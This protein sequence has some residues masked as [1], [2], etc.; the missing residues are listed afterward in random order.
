MVLIQRHVRKTNFSIWRHSVEQVYLGYNH[1]KSQHRVYITRLSSRRDEGEKGNLLFTFQPILSLHVF[2]LQEECE[3]ACVKHHQDDLD[4]E[5]TENVAANATLE[6]GDEGAVVTKDDDG[7]DIGYWDYYNALEATT[8]DK[9]EGKAGGKENKKNGENGEIGEDPDEAGIIEVEDSIKEESSSKTNNGED[10]SFRSGNII[11]ENNTSSKSTSNNSTS[12]NS[13]SSNST[14]TVNNIKNG[15]TLGKNNKNKS[16]NSKFLTDNKQSGESNKGKNKIKK[17][18]EDGDSNELSFI[19]EN[20]S[21]N[22]NKSNSGKKG[23]S[24][25]EKNKQNK[26]ENKTIDD[27]IEKDKVDKKDIEKI[28]KE[29]KKENEFLDN[30]VDFLKRRI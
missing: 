23:K 12:S 19:D 7:E 26:K 29:N 4:K 2:C 21:V 9:D 10:Y 15:I 6:S 13:T 25:K 16:K 30:L 18:E 11:D 5:I 27:K 28:I 20:K 14:S 3:Q 24:S 17:T 1:N 22:E 8:D